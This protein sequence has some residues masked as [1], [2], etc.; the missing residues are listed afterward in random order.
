MASTPSPAMSATPSPMTTPFA[1]PSSCVGNWNYTKT[2]IGYYTTHVEIYDIGPKSDACNYGQTLNIDNRDLA[3]RFSPGVC[4]SGWTAYALQIETSASGN[5]RKSSATCCPSGFSRT[6]ARNGTGGACIQIVPQTKPV[7]LHDYYDQIE[8]TL[9][10]PIWLITWAKSDTKTMKPQ[11]PSL[12]GDC[13]DAEIATWVPGAK[14]TDDQRQCSRPESG[15]GIFANAGTTFLVVGLP[16]LVVAIPSIFFCCIKPRL[17]RIRKERAQ[18][19]AIELQEARNAQ[20][21]AANDV[22]PDTD[23]GEN[24]YD[25]RIIQA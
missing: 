21:K 23:G 1:I 8:T 2:E 3:L 9:F 22:V 12:A 18:Q 15:G 25:T 14:V 13:S 17:R 7:T 16:I 11:P 5:S 10:E 4:P 6:A 19:H 24:D 20:A